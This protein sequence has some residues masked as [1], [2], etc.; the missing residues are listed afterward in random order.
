VTDLEVLDTALDTW[1]ETY[2][3]SGAWMSPAEVTCAEEGFTAGWNAHAALVKELTE[4]EKAVVVSF[5]PDLDW[6]GRLVRNAWIVWAETQ[7]DV[8]DHPNWLVSWDELPERERE[9]DRII[10]DAVLSTVQL[11]LAARAA[12]AQE[13]EAP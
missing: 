9:V 8:K 5:N 13:G 1:I 6:W 2:K 10:A 4:A 11:A 3:R 7:P 12:A